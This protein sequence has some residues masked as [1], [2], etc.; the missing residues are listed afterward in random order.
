MIQII[1]KDK[2]YLLTFGVSIM[3]IIF[4]II[5]LISNKGNKIENQYGTWLCSGTYNVKLELSFYRNADF[6]FKSSN[7]SDSIYVAGLYT[8]EKIYGEDKNYT[9]YRYT[10]TPH[11]IIRNEVEETEYDEVQYEVAFNKN[12]NKIIINSTSGNE[13]YSCRKQ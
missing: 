10:L 11:K 9:Y 2:K 13:R 6:I 4:F 3:F 1:D 12:N 5:L 7:E 8:R